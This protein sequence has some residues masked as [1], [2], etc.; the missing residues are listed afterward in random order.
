MSIWVTVN[1]L[2]KKYTNY[3]ADSIK[4]I[5]EFWKRN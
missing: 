5:H 1:L 3:L 2:S 4:K